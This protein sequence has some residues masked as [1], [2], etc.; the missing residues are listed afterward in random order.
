MNTSIAKRSRRNTLPPKTQKP[1]EE[2]G[3]KVCVS[4]RAVY[5]KRFW[6]HDKEEFRIARHERQI[7]VDHVICPACKMIAEHRY[8]GKLVLKDVP[9]H[10]SAELINL[11]ISF[12]KKA[13]KYNPEHRLI[14]VQKNDN[15]ITLTTTQNKLAVMLAKKVRDVFKRVDMRVH[16]GKK[17][18][19]STMVW[20][21]FFT[22][23]VP[24]FLT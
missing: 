24:A 23:D 18:S 20:M 1:L 21:K 4:C 9:S 12:C 14:E 10:Y 16:H 6:H 7:E 8:E 19:E 2:K 3:V 22:R 13:R 5:E 17:P 15:E 11:G